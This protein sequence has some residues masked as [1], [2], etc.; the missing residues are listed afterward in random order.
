MGCCCSPPERVELTLNS[1][2]ERNK[3]QGLNGPRD[4]MDYCCLSPERVELAVNNKKETNGRVKL[5]QE[6]R[7]VAVVGI[8]F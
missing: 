6:S 5:D 3:W 1:K 4:K 2:K 8:L 7:W